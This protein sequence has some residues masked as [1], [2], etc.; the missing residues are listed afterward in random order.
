M[1]TNLL[2]GYTAYSSPQAIAADR[3]APRSAADSDLISATFTVTITV[4]ITWTWTAA[5]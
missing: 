1:S 4:S 2:E 3:I 5:N